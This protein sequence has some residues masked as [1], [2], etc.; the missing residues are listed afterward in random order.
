M[1]APPLP[2][3]DGKNGPGKVHLGRVVL[4]VVWFY[5]YHVISTQ[6]LNQNT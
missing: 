5:K 4:S 2:R 3:A 6:S 1:L